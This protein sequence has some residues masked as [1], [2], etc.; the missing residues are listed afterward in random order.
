[1][2]FVRFF[3]SVLLALAV[4]VAIVPLLVSTATATGPVITAVSPIL[5][6]QTQ[7]ITITGSGFGT[8][9][10]YD[11]NSDF[12]RISD[13]TRNWNAGSTRD[14]P[15]DFIT[16]A[17]TSWTDSQIVVSGFTGAYGKNN[18]WTLNLGDWVE[19]QIW[20]A[21]TGLGPAAYTRI[22]DQSAGNQPL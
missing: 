19:V 5:P 12:I 6:Q 2:Q 11:G 22:V 7:T 17:I 4:A 18:N 8:L 14:S 3:R 10:P 21:Q 1:L 13:L 15:P 9:Q 20:N 16:L